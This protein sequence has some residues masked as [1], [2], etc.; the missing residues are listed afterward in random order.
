MHLL[1][2]IYTQVCYKYKGKEMEELILSVAVELILIFL[3]PVIGSELLRKRQWFSQISLKSWWLIFIAASMI[4]AASTYVVIHLY[5]IP[6]ASE[7]NV[8]IISLGS[9]MGYD[10]ALMAFTTLTL[11]IAYIMVYMVGGSS[12]HKSFAWFFC[13]ASGIR[14]GAAA[15]NILL[16]Q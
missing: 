3:I 9:L 1:K 8:A 6:W 4:D 12:Y 11:V 2:I 15:C 13:V 14:L 10:E 7:L 5:S 16:S